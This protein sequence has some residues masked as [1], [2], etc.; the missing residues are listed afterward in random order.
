VA[1]LVPTELVVLMIMPY[2]CL[3]NAKRTIEF[4]L[5]RRLPQDIE[6]IRWT[7]FVQHVLSLVFLKKRLRRDWAR[8]SLL[9]RARKQVKDGWM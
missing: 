1:S 8:V 2:L 3:H 7:D 5:N 6:K 9:F 4:H